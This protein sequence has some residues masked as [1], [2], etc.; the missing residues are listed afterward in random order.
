MPRLLNAIKSTI[1][2]ERLE[3]AD[4]F[5]KRKKG[6]VGLR[7]MP[8]GYALLFPHTFFI[9]TFGMKFPIDVVY[10][11]K[12]MQVVKLVRALRPRRFS[13]SLKARMTVELPVN[14]IERCSIEV[15]DQLT[16]F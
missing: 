14:T 6:L 3:I 15:G 11:N 13:I 10:L 16:K 4:S 1:I 2:A 12:K 9:H 7:E 5:S 8:T